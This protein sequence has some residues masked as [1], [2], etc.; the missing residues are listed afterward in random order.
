M[1]EKGNAACGLLKSGNLLFNLVGF[2]D[3]KLFNLNAPGSYI[4]WFHSLLGSSVG[5]PFLCMQEKG[6]AA[7]GLL[8]SGNCLWFSVAPLLILILR[9]GFAPLIMTEN[10]SV[11]SQHINHVPMLALAAVNVCVILVFEIYVVCKASRNTPS[12]RHLF[13]GQARIIHSNTILSLFA[14]LLCR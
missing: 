7:C 12:R 8:K 4:P 5:L 14:F 3:S 2:V 11:R 9:I 1:Q 13:L 10:P 6:N